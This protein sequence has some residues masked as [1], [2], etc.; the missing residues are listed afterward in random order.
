MRKIWHITLPG[1]TSTIVI[2]LILRMGQIMSIGFDRPY[3]LGNPLV[4][5]FSEVIS[6]FNYHYGLRSARYSLATA[7]GLFQSV[8]GIA[9]L[10]TTNQIA[11]RAGES[12]I[13]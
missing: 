5:D 8:V 9:F 12:S 11:K 1:I 6:T 10:V 4:T 2:M 7:V 13:W 3:I